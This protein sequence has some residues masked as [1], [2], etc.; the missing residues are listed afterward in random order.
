MSCAVWRSEITELPTLRVVLVMKYFRFSYW[1]YEKDV[2]GKFLV[3]WP[4]VQL[5]TVTCRN[6]TG[7]ER[8]N[9]LIRFASGVRCHWSYC[10]AWKFIK[11]SWCWRLACLRSY[12]RSAV[13]AMYT[14]M[15]RHVT[16]SDMVT[17]TL[18]RHL[19]IWSARSLVHVSCWGGY[20]HVNHFDNISFNVSMNWT[21]ICA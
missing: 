13:S 2:H 5:G 6:S 11:F 7:A 21:S 9:P 8:S 19:G 20:D 12:S 14:G 4:S 16:T 17:I 1:N 3:V 18:A 10:S 15:V